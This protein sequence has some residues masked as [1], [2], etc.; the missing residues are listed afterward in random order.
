M[1]SVLRR[2]HQTQ[3]ENWPGVVTLLR[4][5]SRTPVV[6]SYSVTEWF[7]THQPPRCAEVLRH[8][9]EQLG[10]PSLGLRPGVALLGEHHLDLRRDEAAIRS[11]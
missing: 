8:P 7:Q 11:G 5:T 2:A 9:A 4:S 10:E 6:M 1:R 3:Y